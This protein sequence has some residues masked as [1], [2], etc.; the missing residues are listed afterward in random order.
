MIIHILYWEIPYL[1]VVPEIQTY[2]FIRWFPGYGAAHTE[3]IC[4]KNIY[5]TSGLNVLLNTTLGL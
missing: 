5:V 2:I 4:L 3:V 1:I